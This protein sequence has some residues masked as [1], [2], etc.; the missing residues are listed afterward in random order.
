MK[1]W[2]WIGL[3]AGAALTSFGVATAWPEAEQPITNLGSR[4]VYTAG[5]QDGT[6][7][8]PPDS[9][10]EPGPA[11]IA[12]PV[13]VRIPALDV[14]AKVEPV[15]LD[16][17]A[18]LAVPDNIERVGWYNLGVPP[19]APKGSAVLAAHRDGVEQGRGVFYHLGELKPGNKVVITLA[20]GQELDYEVVARES[21]AK[22]RLPYEELFAISGEPR[23]T[24]ISCGG[25]YDKDKGGYQDNVV[26]T[27]VPKFESWK[28]K[29]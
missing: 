11:V 2:A 10:S 29:A 19:G 15:G 25:Y 5:E 17:N 16:E 26:V 9:E 22:N 6:A 23:L 13:K 3:L 24:L 1:N 8:K 21:I 27:A 20:D 28:P 7:T 14:Q 4:P 12:V 18:A